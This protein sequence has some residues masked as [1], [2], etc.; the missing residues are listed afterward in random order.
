[1]NLERSTCNIF[2]YGTLKPGEA[3]YPAYCEAKIVSQLAV[4]TRGEL[5]TLPV[6]YPA[7]TAGNHKVY[8]CCLSFRDSSILHDLDG[9]E[10]YD[11][12]RSPDLN[13]Y[14]R[15]LTPIY[16]LGDR[17]LGRAWAYFMNPERVVRY[18]GEK[19][20]SGWWSDRQPFPPLNFH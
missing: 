20:T 10:D 15:A 6:G 4:Y 12:H 3:N 18:R 17:L 14:Y 9:L 8:G 19:V 2:V 1:M 13:E 11:E 16:S 7:I 5:Y